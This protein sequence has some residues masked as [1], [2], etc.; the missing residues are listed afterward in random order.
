MQKKIVDTSSSISLGGKAQNFWGNKRIV[1]SSKYNDGFQSTN[2]TVAT[3]VVKKY[4]LKGFE[5]GNWLNNNDRYDFLLATEKS[6]SDLSK[7]IGSKNIGL[8]ANIGIAFGARGIPSAKAHFE[9]KTFMIN[10][11]KENGHNSLAH[12]YGHALD[13][14]FGTF[15]DQNRN[16]CSLSGGHFTAKELR[17]NNG[18]RLRLLM[19]NVLRKVIF[20]E[21]NELTDSYK[22]LNQYKNGEYWFRRCEIFARAFEQ[23]I[24]FKLGKIKTVNTFL[25]KDKMKYEGSVYL[26]EKDFKRV[27]PA[28]DALVKEMSCYMKNKAPRKNKVK[29][30]IKTVV[31]GK[32]NV[33][34]KV[35]N[36]KVSVSIQTA[37]KDV[38]TLK[39]Y[40]DLKPMEAQ[41]L[42][43][44]K[45]NASK[46]DFEENSLISSIASSLTKKDYFYDFMGKRGRYTQKG[47][48]FIKS[49]DARIETLKGKK[50]GYTLF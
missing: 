5:F 19:D 46:L 4:K 10:L 2:P 23:Y 14:F 32:I 45:K 8:D 39:K 20:N 24:M 25:A 49:V 22:R 18:G 21:K 50:Y 13:Y 29:E 7:I 11:T 42:Y 16:H 33:K 9:P 1:R 6:L 15:I 35:V 43:S 3:E 40:S 41:I 30:S 48:E 37:I 36:K 17:D 27:I 47:R 31:S 44:L 26:L 34:P 28:M 38:L 12:E